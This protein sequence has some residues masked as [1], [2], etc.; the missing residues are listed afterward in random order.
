MKYMGSK[1]R[2]AKYIL[3]IMLEY[4][5]EEMIWVEPFVGGANM[6]DKVKGKRIGAD[7]NPYLIDALIAIRDCVNDL[8][9]DN[10]EFTEENYKEL[11]KDDKYKYKGYAGFAF[12]YSGKWLGGWCRDG[13]NKRDYVNESYKNAIK[14][15]PKLKDVK[16]IQSSYD[17]L[18]LNSDNCLI[19]CDPPYKGTTS[20]KDSFD[21]IKFWNWC[22]EMNDRGHKI[23]VSEY[24]APDDFKCIWQKEIVSSLT[25]NTGSKKGIEKLFTLE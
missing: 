17:E 12:S 22:R 9:K 10:K 23:F 25:K 4:K 3:P 5:T 11:R 18:P 2:I 21:H 6:I 7:I 8:P 20:Y 15:S 1:N 19:Y 16:F 13:L 24:N 14:Q